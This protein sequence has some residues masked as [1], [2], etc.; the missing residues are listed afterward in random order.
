MDK[1]ILELYNKLKQS[2]IKNSLLSSYWIFHIESVIVKEDGISKRYLKVF[3]FNRKMNEKGQ[4]M[5]LYLKVHGEHIEKDDFVVSTQ[6]QNPNIMG[7]LL[8]RDLIDES[9]DI[10]IEGYVVNGKKVELDDECI[11]GF[12]YIQDVRKFYVMKTLHLLREDMILVPYMD[13]EKW[14]CTCGYCNH[15][16]DLI[17]P[18]CARKKEEAVRLI[19]KTEKDLIFSH[20]NQ[21][22]PKSIEKPIQQVIKEYV[23]FLSNEYHI[24][25]EELYEHVDVEGLAQQQDVQV[26]QY[27]QSYLNSNKIN[28]KSK[29]DIHEAI[30]STCAPILNDMITI[31]KIEKHIDL[32]QLQRE[33][34]E[35]QAKIDIKG[36]KTRK[37]SIVIGVSAIVLCV[38]FC[39]MKII[40]PKQEETK[41]PEPIQ[42][43]EDT[44]T[45]LNTYDNRKE[46]CQGSLDTIAF[47]NEEIKSLVM[48]NQYCPITPDYT[49]Y[50]QWQVVV[51]DNKTIRTLDDTH[52]W[53]KEV[54]K[55]GNKGKEIY[56]IGDKF[57]NPLS[58]HEQDYYVDVEYADEKRISAV[59]YLNQERYRTEIYEYTTDVDYKVEVFEK[60][61]FK[62]YYYYE[63]DRIVSAEIYNPIFTV[64]KSEAR[65]YYTDDDTYRIEQYDMSTKK[66][67]NTKYF[68]NGFLLKIE[69]EDSTG[70]MYYDKNGLLAKVEWE[71]NGD[72][73]QIFL[74]DYDF[75][76]SEYTRVFYLKD[77]NENYQLY[78]CEKMKYMIMDEQA[79][80][81]HEDAFYQ[82]RAVF[83]NVSNE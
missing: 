54:T 26:D 69:Y 51:K 65:W 1:I 31:E 3:F 5:R 40:Y 19:Q 55:N 30:R 75:E 56:Y 76:R 50:P 34:D 39:I 22:I 38:V 79:S 41:I 12:S 18:I 80:T 45:I 63:N 47:H 52:T 10:Q 28:L 59:S 7:F 11:Q 64:E 61:E 29:A 2:S 15:I 67:M 21:I 78:N 68:E 20:I 57:G 71:I 8:E 46:H 43:T 72:G 74:H 66:L 32:E 60:G 35:L 17:C 48:D 53:V 23:E 44:F 27:I 70:H 36:Q 24:S 81:I 33:F 73:N 6:Y 42:T 82:D 16:D 62:G 13:K 49:Q 25:K 37:Y 14:I 58:N 83:E 77:R 4:L 9:I